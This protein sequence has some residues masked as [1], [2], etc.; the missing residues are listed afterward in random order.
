VAVDGEQCWNSGDKI[1]FKDVAEIYNE[2]RPYR[3]YVGNEGF[4]LL[5]YT[6]L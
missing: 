4:N 2:M 5:H 6:R 1:C 3:G